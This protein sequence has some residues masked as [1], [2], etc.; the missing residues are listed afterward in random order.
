MPPLIGRR[1]SVAS[2]LDDRQLETTTAEVVVVVVAVCRRWR[3]GRRGASS[4]DLW[5]WT[6]W[7]PT[8]G[9]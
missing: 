5:L 7:G 2:G 9:D 1:V 8:K 4:D 3:I 6:T